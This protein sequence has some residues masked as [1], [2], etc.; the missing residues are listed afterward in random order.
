MYIQPPPT[1]RADNQRTVNQSQSLL[2]SGMELS[3]MT[4]E[5]KA[6]EELF[7]TNTTQQQDGRFV[8]RLPTKMEPYHLGNSRS[9]A[10]K[11]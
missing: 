3:T 10:E 7:I 4:A 2:G 1:I 9:A 11:R 8:V 5:Q 6:C